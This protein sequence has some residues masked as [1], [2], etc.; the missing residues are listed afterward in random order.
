MGG[1]VTSANFDGTGPMDIVISASNQGPV[2]T[3]RVY[4]VLGG[5]QLTSGSI[6][7]LPTGTVPNGFQ[8]DP[9]TASSFFGSTVTGVGTGGDGFGD[10]V[11][12]AAGRTT[13]AISGAAYFIPGRAHSGVAGLNA[14]SATV[15]TQFATG[16]PSQYALSLGSV[17][18]FNGDTFND[19][20]VVHDFQTANGGG[21]CTLFLGQSLVSGGG[22]TSSNTLEFV[23]DVGDNDWGFFS[24][25]GFSAGLGLLGD[26]NN[27]GFGE[28]LLGSQ[29]TGGFN[30]GT[31][32]L[33][34]GRAGALARPRTDADM[35]F[36]TAD[37]GHI[38]PAFVG[39]ING[40]G[41]KD[42]AMFDT[43][44]GTTSKVTL[45]Y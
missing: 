42:M 26:L 37:Q 10:L 43:D 14:V 41:F 30:R 18:D 13:G 44:A 34:Y 31:G 35:T 4:V 32:D 33:F 45:L 27:D 8:I 23:N 40:D 38:A 29:T 6:F 12:G 3:G 22:F 39:D 9:T 5:S 2:N 25:Q 24:A 20:C 16:S 17:G 7:T 11:I 15:G 19:V 21:S 1:P 36:D 28:L